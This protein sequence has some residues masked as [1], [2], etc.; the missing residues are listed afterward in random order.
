MQRYRRRE[1]WLPRLTASAPPQKHFADYYLSLVQQ[2]PNSREDM[3]LALQIYAVS[4][5][6]RRLQTHADV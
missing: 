3:G 1:L 6:S 4:K 2:R 5:L